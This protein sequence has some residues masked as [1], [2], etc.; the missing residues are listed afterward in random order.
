MKVLGTINATFGGSKKQSVVDKIKSYKFEA[1][2]T[3]L[4][5]KLQRIYE[6]FGEL[7][8]VAK[9]TE[10]VKEFL[11]SGELEEIADIFNVV[12]QLYLNNPELR[13][14]CEYKVNRTLDRIEDNYY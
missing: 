12:T 7:H 11:E 13:D 9:L 4:L 14:M 10:E 8:Q 3:T 1:V 2:S 5:E 6:N